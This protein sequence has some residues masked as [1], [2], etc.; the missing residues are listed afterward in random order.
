MAAECKF[1]ESEDANAEKRMHK[2]IQKGYEQLDND[3]KDDCNEREDVHA[4][5]NKSRI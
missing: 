2:C 3:N 5:P 1:G 4:S